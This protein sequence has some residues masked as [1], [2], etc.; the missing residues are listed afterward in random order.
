MLW[1]GRPPIDETARTFCP[2]CLAFQ[3][4]R[5]PPDPRMPLLRR[6]I[7]AVEILGDFPHLGLAVITLMERKDLFISANQRSAPLS[8]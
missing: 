1:A 7:G 4:F 2:T 5:I 6:Q 8:L 3:Q